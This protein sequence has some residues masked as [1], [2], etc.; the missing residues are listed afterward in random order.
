MHPE[1][2]EFMRV[3]GMTIDHIGEALVYSDIH[4][5]KMTIGGNLHQ[6]TTVEHTAGMPVQSAEDR[7]KMQYFLGKEPTTKPEPG[8]EYEVKM[9]KLRGWWDKHHGNVITMLGHNY[10]DVS[11][12]AT[13]TIRRL[14]K[15]PQHRIY[16]IKVADVLKHHMMPGSILTLPDGEYA[17]AIKKAYAWRSREIGKRTISAI[18]CNVRHR[19]WMVGE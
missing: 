14:I 7:S 17:L 12:F 8:T 11:I 6:V 13:I 2:I 3:Y 19:I 18:K 9:V 16:L 15:H 1:L 4:R 10:N 5:Y